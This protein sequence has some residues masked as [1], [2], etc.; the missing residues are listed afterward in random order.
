M[1]T[2]NQLSQT[3]PRDLNADTD[4]NERGQP[5][6]DIDTCAPKTSDERR[7]KA[8]RHVDG[9]RECPQTKERGAKYEREMSRVG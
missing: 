8:I 4:K 1:Q 3:R 9:E 2:G 7:S 6:Q 5:N